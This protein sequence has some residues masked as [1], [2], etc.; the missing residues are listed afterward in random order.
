M[1]SRILAG[2]SY[3][4]PAYIL[5]PEL[6]PSQ[7]R[8][9]T[10]KVSLFDLHG[11]NRNLKTLWVEEKQSFA[12]RIKTGLRKFHETV[13]I[14][15]II[16]KWNCMMTTCALQLQLE[17]HLFKKVKSRFCLWAAFAILKTGWRVLK[18]LHIKKGFQSLFLQK[19]P[20][21]WCLYCYKVWYPVNVAYRYICLSLKLRGKKRNDSYFFP[22]I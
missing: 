14:M 11:W 16:L 5:L 3:F 9:S 1:C 2:T 12:R 13:K 18:Y 15:N 8:G 7:V 22:Y 19:S 6:I 21:G 20:L 17:F 4:L 10:A